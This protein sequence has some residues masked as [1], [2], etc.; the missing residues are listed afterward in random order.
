MKESLLKK[1]FSVE[2]GETGRVGL[3]LIMS[4]FMGA[5]LATFSVAAQTQFLG[6]HNGSQRLPEAFVLSG[7]FGLFATLTYNFLQNRIP[8]RL[9]AILSLITITIIAAFI[10]FGHEYVAMDDL[11][12]RFFSYAQIAPFTLVVLLVF[13]GTFNRLFNVKQ[14]KRLLGSVDQGALLA[15]LISFFTIPILLDYIGVKDLFT[16]SLFGII[17]FT[18]LFI[19][20][21]SRFADES[22][23]L[24]S[25]KQFNQ[26]L[27]TVSFFKNKYVLFLSLFIIASMVALTFVDYSF[28]NAS[29]E[30]FRD[31]P[32]A[33]PKFLSY[34]E[35]TV[36]IFSFLFQT[37]AADRVIADYG[38][39]TSVLV[40]PI[41]IGIFTIV[42][43]T[44]GLSFGYTTASSSF[45]IFF[46]MIA[47][48]KLF[49]LS[50]KESLDEPSFKLYLLPIETNIKID[51]QT[52]LE[53]VVTGFATLVAGALILGIQKFNL[54]DLIYM[55]VFAIPLIVAW[56]FVAGKLYGIYRETLQTTLIKNKAKVDHKIDREY[57][58]DK[59]LEKEINSTAEDK[60]IYGLKLME[61][62]EPT[63]F[64]NAVIR[65]T[66]SEYTKVKS[67][68][69][70]KIQELGIDKETIKNPE[71]RNLAKSAQ[72]EAEDSD[73]LSISPDKLMK[74]SKSVKPADRILAAKLLRKLISQ[75]TIFILLELLRDVSVHVRHEA[76]ITAR[77][78]KRPET[79]SVL[80]E[81]LSSPTYGHDAAAAL[82]EAGPAALPV[83]EASF[84]KSG[85]TDLVMLRIVQ[86]MGRIGGDDALALLWK[87]ADYPDK[88]IVKQI[89]YSLRYINYRATGRQAQEVTELL[90]TE[91]GKTIWNLAALSEL[92]DEAEYAL[93]R[94]AIREEIRSNFD[95][96]TM[97]L[98][99][100][101]DPEAVQLVRENIESGDPNGVA[102]A[103]ELMDLFVEK[104]LKPKLFP[105]FDDIPVE[106][107][108]EQLQIYFPRESYNPIQVINYILNRDFNMNNRW[109]KVCAVYVSAYLKDFRVSRGLIAQMFNQDKMLQETAAWVI[110]NKDKNF[111]KVISERLPVRDKKFLD[112]SIENNQLLDGLDDGFFL[113]IEM[114]LF[115]KQ[116]PEFKNINGVLLA[117]LFDKISPIDLNE[118][119]KLTFDAKEQGMPIIIVALGEIILKDDATVIKSL[120]AG[121]VYGDIFQ[122]GLAVPAKSI[123]ATQ[124]SIVF[125]INLADFYFVMA[126]HHELVEGLIKNITSTQ[127]KANVLTTEL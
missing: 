83:L 76:L 6:I 47:M 102:Y 33:L 115:L 84:H 51:V 122:N 50:V 121:S 41:L 15:S 67:F 20:L 16:I 43:L 25:E 89:L 9:L 7:I 99:I 23:S 70:E 34:F 127:A 105:L 3:L 109:T 30:F 36:V 118:G 78:V 80:V 18:I 56:Y 39:K 19:V 81:L 74:L 46:I 62:L 100:L 87:K 37:F 86:I 77:K 2:E 93:L 21:S 28:L 57:T 95:H 117:D 35:A 44:I 98:S 38:L 126:N 116:L 73:L 64:E 60:V 13:W 114:V 17:I 40:N 90:E 24:K 59:V 75:R 119:Q 72:G 8:F 29:T 1:V 14:S 123:E 108:L 42:A 65:L 82:I 103:L 68:A 26:K 94:D 96:I 52:K 113:G 111:Y 12:L 88:R 54:V 66:E 110:Y 53:G 5:F 10:E 107:K 106:Q 45:I 32:G 11:Y 69:V 4:F 71:I 48:S 104:D 101:Y 92:P 61:K 120:K 85:Q 49:V 55:T 97:L 112:S 124:R 79:W 63:L 31:K 91:L 27:S 58:V 22:W 125:K